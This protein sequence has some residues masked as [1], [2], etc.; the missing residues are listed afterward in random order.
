M[1]QGQNIALWLLVLYAVTQKAA[2]DEISLHPNFQA[3]LADFY[4]WGT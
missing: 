1:L 2:N 3:S 4:K